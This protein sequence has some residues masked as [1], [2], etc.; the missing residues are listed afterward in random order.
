M[1]IDET[2]VFSMWLLCGYCVATVWLLCGYC[3][4]PLL[5]D[6][7]QFEI[8]VDGKNF[9]PLQAHLCKRQEFIRNAA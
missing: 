2:S 3:M 5:R 8:T 1:H 7:T 4:Y 6:A 9:A